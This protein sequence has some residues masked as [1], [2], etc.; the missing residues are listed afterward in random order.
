MKEVFRNFLFAMMQSKGKVFTKKWCK[1]QIEIFQ[2][3]EGKEEEEQFLQ[4]MKELH[5]L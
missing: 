3:L 2:R 5:L 4:A 1:D